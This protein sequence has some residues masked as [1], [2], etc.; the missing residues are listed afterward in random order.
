M[1]VYFDP[2]ALGVV[3]GFILGVIALILFSLMYQSR[4]KKK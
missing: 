2:L 1:T 4:D 3:I